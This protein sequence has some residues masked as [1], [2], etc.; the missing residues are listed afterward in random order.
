MLWKKNQYF[1]K[2][3]F[4]RYIILF[5]ILLLFSQFIILKSFK[6]YHKNK[7][8]NCTNAFAFIKYLC[9]W[10]HFLSCFHQ[11]F[12]VN[13]GMLFGTS[14]LNY[15]CH[16]QTR[17]IC[18]TTVNLSINISQLEN[19]LNSFTSSQHKCFDGMQKFISF[20]MRQVWLK[21]IVNN[22]LHQFFTDF[23]LAYFFFLSR[24]LLLTLNEMTVFCYIKSLQYSNSNCWS[25]EGVTSLVQ[26]HMQ[27][28]LS[29]CI[30]DNE[31]KKNKKKNR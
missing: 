4:N 26:R 21:K 9:K 15:L 27:L 12:L 2:F 3:I 18:L 23:V 10:A 17:N 6:I 28:F 30:K 8:W 19:F 20:K 16:W 24:T 13:F 22:T 1:H 7:L 5:N 29:E 14:M 11:Q 25:V 31:K